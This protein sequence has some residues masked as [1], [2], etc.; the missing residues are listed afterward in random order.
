LGDAGAIHL[1]RGENSWLAYGDW[2]P[3]GLRGAGIGPSD[4]KQFI[5]VNAIAYTHLENVRKSEAHF[6]GW[7]DIAGA[8]DCCAYDERR[9]QH[10]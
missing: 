5:L 4:G 7:H 1:R 6:C 2:V 10:L 9:N 8:S 3:F